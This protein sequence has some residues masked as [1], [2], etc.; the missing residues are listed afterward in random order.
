MT[1]YPDGSSTTNFETVTVT[2]NETITFSGIPTSTE[3]PITWM[4]ED[5]VT[6]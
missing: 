3:V 5:G 1:V 6:G 4:L 2:E